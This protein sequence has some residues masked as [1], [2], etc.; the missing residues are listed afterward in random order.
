MKPRSGN[1]LD[2]SSAGS[3]QVVA[4]PAS[5][6]AQPPIQVRRWVR[7]DKHPDADLENQKQE[8]INQCAML[9]TKQI[10]IGMGNVTT[11]PGVNKA[12]WPRWRFAFHTGPLAHALYVRSVQGIPFDISPNAYIQMDLYSDATESTLVSSTQ[13]HYG[14][15]A[16]NGGGSLGWQNM[17]V[18]DKY[19]DVVADTSYYAVIRNVNSARNLSCAVIELASM[20]QNNSGYLA[21]NLV[22]QGNILDVYREKQANLI[23]SLWKR[24]GSQ[25]LNWTTEPG[26]LFP[27]GSG[28]A[29]NWD[30]KFTSSATATNILDL[31]STTIS[32]ATPGWT[33]DMT[34]KARLMQPLG[35]PCLM[36]VFAYCD[37]GATGIV[38]LKDSAGNVVASVAVTATTPQWTAS[39]AFNWPASS[40][41]YD[42]HYRR[43]SGAGA[44]GMYLWAVS[45]Y[46]YE[47]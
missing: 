26:N 42:I 41:K 16:L 9:R 24:G 19:V 46:E 17:R 18:I 29:P 23:K 14:G 1:R 33:I 25:V 32:A 47:A 45:V 30:Y 37:V 21:Q 5:R 3:R 15:D 38:E 10:F 36:K 20:T 12:G 22:A 2:V 4:N 7:N 44:L 43:T 28:P 11:G 6:K 39:A 35:A 8:H 31:T 34:G 40:A 27:S 13:F